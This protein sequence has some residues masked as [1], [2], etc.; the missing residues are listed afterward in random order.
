M[1]GSVLQEKSLFKTLELSLTAL[2]PSNLDFLTF[3]V[4]S[5]YFSIHDKNIKQ[6]RCVKV[7]NLTVLF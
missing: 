6:V 7:Q 1:D 2:S 5:K 3:Y 4:T